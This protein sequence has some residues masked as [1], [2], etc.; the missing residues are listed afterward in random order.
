MSPVC[1]GPDDDK[2][3]RLDGSYG[4]LLLGNWIVSAGYVDRWFGPGQEGSLILSDNARPVP[5]VSIERNHADA[6]ENFLLSWI[7]P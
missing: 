7:G 5:S 2:R 6:Y 1:C 4:A 3:L